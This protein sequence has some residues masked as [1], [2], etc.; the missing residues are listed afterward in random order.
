MFYKI[1]DS[2]KIETESERREHALF[3]KLVKQKSTFQ[4]DDR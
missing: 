3:A 1:G 2:S 4:P